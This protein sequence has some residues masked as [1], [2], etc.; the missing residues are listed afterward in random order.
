MK[1]DYPP[2]NQRIRDIIDTQFGGKVL[3]FCNAIG[4]ETSQRSIGCSN[5]T[6]EI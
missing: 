5:W 3:P 1:E 6:T 2:I 4:F